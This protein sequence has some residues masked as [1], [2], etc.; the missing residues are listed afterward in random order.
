VVVSPARRPKW[1][2]LTVFG[3]E[4]PRLKDLDRLDKPKRRALGKEEEPYERGNC[5]R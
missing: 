5:P 3:K 2:K 4:K 1:S